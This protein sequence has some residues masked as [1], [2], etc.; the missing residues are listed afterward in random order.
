MNDFVQP[1]GYVKAAG[2]LLLVF[3]LGAVAGPLIAS[4][5]IRFIG[6]DSLFAYTACIH[7]ALA[8]F[9]FYRMGRRAPTPEEEHIT[10]GDALRVSQTVSNVDLRSPA[11]EQKR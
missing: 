8:G 11:P 3:A 10:F 7:V 2:G 5:V 4:L 1:E 6:I 9:A